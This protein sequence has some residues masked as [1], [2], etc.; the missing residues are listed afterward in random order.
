MGRLENLSGGP[1]GTA[2]CGGGRLAGADDPEARA[3]HACPRARQHREHRDD[4]RERRARPAPLRGHAVP[5]PARLLSCQGA[6][7]AFTRYVASFWGG[8]GIR[9]NAILPGPFSN[10]EEMTGNSVDPDD[11]F[12]ARLAART[13][14]RRTRAGR[15][16]RGR[17]PVSRLGRLHLR[18]RPRPGRR[19]R[20]DGTVKARHSSTRSRA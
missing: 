5:E 14:L 17:P 20:V 1:M 13:C 12:L 19:W 11:P 3:G 15:G 2:L 7:V 4:V 6:M 10:T 18:D 8:D 16:V 9:A